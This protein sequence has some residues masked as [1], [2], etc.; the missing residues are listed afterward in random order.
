[1]KKYLNLSV[2]VLL[3]ALTLTACSESNDSDNEESGFNI[4][5]TAPL[6]DEDS[7]PLNTLDGNYSQKQFGQTAMDDCDELGS[8]LVKANATIAKAQLNSQQEAF[9]YKVLENLVDNVIVP[10]YKQ[11]ADNTED[12]EKTLHGL[13][14]ANIT[15]AQIDKACTDF[16]A[17]RLYWERSEAFLGGAAADFDIDPTIDSRPLNHS[18]LL[19][20]LQSGRTDFSEEEIEDATSRLAVPQN[21]PTHSASA[22]C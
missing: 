3:G 18:L 19:T 6:T 13:T 8:Q 2:A 22:R 11:L 20:Y 12:L 5:K 15:Q 4:V 21:W 1:M 9:L 17:A 14:A 7:Y 16:K 10:T